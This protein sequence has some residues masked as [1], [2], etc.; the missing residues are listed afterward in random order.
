MK[1]GEGG[2]VAHGTGATS[3]VDRIDNALQRSMRTRSRDGTGVEVGH[4]SRTGT[5]GITVEGR[6]ARERIKEIGISG[7]LR[8]ACQGQAEGSSVRRRSYILR[9]NQ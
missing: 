5:S 4:A 6:G 9:W 2:Q 7:R 1:A 8:K 3:D